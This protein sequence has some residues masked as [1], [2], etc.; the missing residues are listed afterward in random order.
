M[1]QKF[2]DVLRLL[3][4]SEYLT[5]LCVVLFVG[6]LLVFLFRYRKGQQKG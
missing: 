3:L 4:L 6:A 2:T 1:V 5:I